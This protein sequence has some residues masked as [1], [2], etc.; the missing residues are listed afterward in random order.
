MVSSKILTLI[1]PFVDD[2]GMLTVKSVPFNVVKSI[3]EEYLFTQDPVVKNEAKTVIWDFCS[4][5]GIFPASINNIYRQRANETLPHN[6]T[7][8]AINVRGLTFFVAGEIIK[9]ASATNTKHFIFELSRSEMRYTDQNWEGYATCVL[10]GALSVGY[11]GPVYIQGDHFQAKPA[12]EGVIAEGEVEAIKS[13]IDEA[14]KNGVYNIDIDSSTLVNLSASTIEEQQRENIKYTLEFA[15]YIRLHEPKDIQISIGGEIGHIGGKNST[16]EELNVFLTGFNEGWDKTHYGLSKV[17]IQSGTSHG[18]TVLGDGSIAPATVDYDLL[19]S[20]SRLCRQ[21]FEV[22]G[23]VQHGA[24]TQPMGF[25]TELPKHEVLEVHLATGI[26]NVIFDSKSFPQELK[27]AMSNWI[28]DKKLDERKKDWSDEQFI[29]KTRKKCWGEFKK[30]LWDANLDL[31]D[32]QT[33]L[34]GY[35][36]ALSI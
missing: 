3:V 29:Y 34:T 25:F 14:I 31:T 26:Q 2:K 17:S 33:L 8:P 15:K 1:A 4:Q 12:A 6:F 10:A 19:L 13:L 5:V 21:N 16:V 35:F 23:V 22:G 7:V 20:A 24:S 36:K 11:T 28:L 9:A 27:Q 18:G 32:L 30:E